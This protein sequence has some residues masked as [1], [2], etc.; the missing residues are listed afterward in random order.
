MLKLGKKDNSLLERGRG[1]VG[2]NVQQ[3]QV[4]E[5]GV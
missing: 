5:G 2:R 4:G 1:G 3:V